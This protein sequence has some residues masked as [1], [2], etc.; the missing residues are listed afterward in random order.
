MK[1]LHEDKKKNNKDV[2]YFTLINESVSKRMHCKFEDQ[3]S[4]D[5]KIDCP[6]PPFEEVGYIAMQMSVG[7]SVGP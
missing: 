3:Y 2:S 4:N 1:V 7:Q 6:P 5:W